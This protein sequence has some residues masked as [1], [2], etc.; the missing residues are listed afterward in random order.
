MSIQRYENPNGTWRVVEDRHDSWGRKT[1]EEVLVADIATAEEA[2][3]A[4]SEAICQKMVDGFNNNSA[5]HRENYTG[6]P[7][8]WTGWVR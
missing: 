5:V 8:G 2:L 7:G 6:K 3:E 4:W 1:S